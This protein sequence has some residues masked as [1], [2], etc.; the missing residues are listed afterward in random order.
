MPP[1]AHHAA[2]DALLSLLVAGSGLT[3]LLTAARA[4]LTRR[5]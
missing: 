4:R 1:L 3:L 2:E 5:R